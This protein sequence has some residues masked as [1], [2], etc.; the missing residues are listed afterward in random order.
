MFQLF[1]GP[2]NLAA[3]WCICFDGIHVEK[4]E[5]VTTASGESDNTK[6]RK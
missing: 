5:E 1:V 4:M 3:V 2:W 6:W